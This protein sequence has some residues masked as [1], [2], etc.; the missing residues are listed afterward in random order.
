MEDLYKEEYPI[1]EDDGSWL[2][3]PDG[4]D[5]SLN[6]DHSTENT[7]TP[8]ACNSTILTG[9]TASD[10][11]DVASPPDGPQQEESSTKPLA[12]TKHE[13]EDSPEEEP[14]RTK[15][16]RR[17]GEPEPDYSAMSR[18][19]IKQN[20][21]TGQACDR[22]KVCQA[23]YPRLSATHDMSVSPKPRPRL[24]NKDTNSTIPPCQLRKLRCDRT[25]NGCV[26]CGAVN[27]PCHVTDRVTG[28]TFLRGEA[29][30][31]KT[32]NEGLRGKIVELEQTI[33][34]LR[35]EN[36]SLQAQIFCYEMVQVWSKRLL[37]Y[38]AWGS[39]LTALCLGRIAK[40][41]YWR[42]SSD[43]RCRHSS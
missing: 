20:K 13:L 10:F 43:L 29:G 22:C 34:Q 26:P 4:H 12:G 8:P 30:Q 19:K 41:I 39:L 23:A 25:P 1:Q 11:L 27:Q 7:S 18:Q 35:S 3:I 40:R 37:V 15:S 9:D 6:M 17:K 24:S 16:R 21:R 42:T 38:D 14:R 36:H 33:D 31:L 2:T 5:I 32:E 28:E